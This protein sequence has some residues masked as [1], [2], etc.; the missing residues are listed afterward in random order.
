MQT[1]G[2]IRDFL[3]YRRDNAASMLEKRKDEW[4]EDY[5]A[6]ERMSPR[7]NRALWIGAYEGEMIAYGEVLREFAGYV[8]HITAVIDRHI[9]SQQ[10]SLS[11]SKPRGM[12]HEHFSGAM[13]ALR[14]LRR[15]LLGDV[16]TAAEQT[17]QNLNKRTEAK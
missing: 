10:T 2:G 1:P 17:A 11:N 16:R 4:A 12:D 7:E 15:E 13:S 14:E 6:D 3:T 5:G 8:P 9:E